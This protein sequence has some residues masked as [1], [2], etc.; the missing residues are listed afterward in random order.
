[1]KIRYLFITALLLLAVRPLCAQ[2]IFTDSVHTVSCNNG[3]DGYWE[4][5]P[6][7]PDHPYV[8]EFST[9]DIVSTDT[10]PAPYI[11]GLPAGTYSC[12]ITGSDFQQY[13]F[14]ISITQ[15]LQVTLGLTDIGHV[16]CFGDSTGF[17]LPGSVHGGT[18]PYSYVWSNGGTSLSAGGLAAGIYHITVTDA[19]NC[20]LIETFEVRQPEEP[21]KFFPE[22]R[23]TSCKQRND[24]SIVLFS[25]DMYNSTGAHTFYV[26]NSFGALLDSL[27]PG[28]DLIGLAPGLYQG[29]LVNEHGCQATKLIYVEQNTRDCI[30]IPNYISAN[31]DLINDVF[32]VEGACDYDEYMLFIYDDT[33]HKV[34]ESSDCAESWDPLKNYKATARTLFYYHIQVVKDGIA[35]KY[36]SSINVNY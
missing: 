31:G 16:K 10:V 24:G 8:A 28:E 21:M 25:E 11:A 12:V 18:A 35:F 26:F 34:F 29:V 6:I 22:S 32:R 4:I 2:T 9:G 14:E 13:Y 20:R 1:M 36:A 3:A 17:I 5:L 27:K 19:L 33:G 30:V 7:G 15:P 23:P